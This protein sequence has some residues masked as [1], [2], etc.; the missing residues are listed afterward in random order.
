MMDQMVNSELRDVKP[1][2]DF[3]SYWWIRV[4][5]ALV[6]VLALVVWLIYRWMKQKNA[7]V[8][9]RARDSWDIAYDQLNRL[10]GEQLIHHGKYQEYFF[11]LSDILRHY[12]EGRFLLKAPEMT[13]E[14]FLVCLHQSPQLNQ[15]QKQGIQDFLTQSDLVKFAKFEPTIAQAD[16]GFQLVKKFVDETK[17]AVSEAK[18]LKKT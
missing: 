6:I 4:S 13:T 2:V 11:R 8:K 17:I 9:V 15:T 1:P 16:T 18:S 10:N 5:V 12:I 14:E 3:P 7:E